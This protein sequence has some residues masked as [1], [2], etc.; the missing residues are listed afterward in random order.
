MGVTVVIGSLTVHPTDTVVYVLASPAMT[1]RDSSTQ[2]S[3]A[4]FTLYDASGELHFQP[5]EPITITDSVAGNMFS[6]YLNTDTENNLYPGDAL[7]HSITCIDEELFLA[8]KRVASGLHDDERMSGQYAGDNV[9]YLLANYLVDEGVT[10]SYAQ[11]TTSTQSDF[12]TGTLTN[13]SALN[14]TIDGDL[15]LTPA[16]GSVTKTESTTA[17]W[18]SNISL[19]G[20][21]TTGGMLRLASHA[22]LQLTGTCGLNFG[23]AFVYQQFWAGSYVVQANDYMTYKVWINSS[24]PQIMCAVDC[25][26]TDGTTMRDV[27]SNGCLDQNGLLAHPKQDLSGFANDQWY[28]RQININLLAGKTISAI[29]IAFEGDSQ[30]TYTGYVYDVI[31]YAA[32]LT[33]KNV[34]VYASAGASSGVVALPTNKA[35]G[36]NGY[37]NVELRAVVGY[38][39]TGTRLASTTSLTPAGIYQN[40]LVSWQQTGFPTD[41]TLAANT[42]PATASLAVNTS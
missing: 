20:L 5:F 2:G 22:T 38:E 1:I 41:A 28:S 18:N 42:I 15:E 33:T 8:G 35:L 9:V 17:D 21:D 19:S 40:S 34:T 30:G 11:Q 24:S 36:D 39:K 29:S 26:C 7:T 6:G 12:A 10:S 3:T 27:G 14:N 37:S 32:N 23:N 13:V 25:V 31:I 16:G 4:N